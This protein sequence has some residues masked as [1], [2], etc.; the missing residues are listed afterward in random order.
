MDSRRM[1]P[2]KRGYD[3]CEIETCSMMIHMEGWKK[4]EDECVKLEKE[5]DATKCR[6]GRDRRDRRQKERRMMIVPCVEAVQ[7]KRIEERSR[8][9]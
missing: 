3:D 4:T 2:K 9:V 1:K 7:A 6:Q 5:C 8:P